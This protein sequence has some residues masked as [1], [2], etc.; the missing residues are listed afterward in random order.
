[1]DYN[2]IRALLE[3]YWEADTSLE[4]EALLRRFFVTHRDALP[5]D[6]RE[7]APLF[8]YFQAESEKELPALPDDR[9][10]PLRRARPWQHW[11]KYAAMLLLLA[12][13]GYSVQ[14]FRQK[15]QQLD[16]SAWQQDTFTDPEKAYRETEKALELLARNLN[17][18]TSQV[19]KLSYF[20]EATEKVKND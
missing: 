4:E 16:L 20:N 3:K 8:S 14:Q 7:A 1:M 13:V 18:G 11:M 10:L 19:E 5:E 2:K 12:G 9:I 15:Q 17:K 6:L